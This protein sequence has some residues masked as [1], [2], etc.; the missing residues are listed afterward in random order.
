MNPLHPQR[1][2]L[3][4]RPTRLP[5]TSW[6]ANRR[7]RRSPHPR[8]R[9][10]SPRVRG[11]HRRACFRPPRRLGSAPLSTP[12]KCGIEHLGG[13]GCRNTCGRRCRGCRCFGCWAFWGRPFGTSAAGSSCGGSRAAR[14]NRFRQRCGGVATPLAQILRVSRPV[15][16]LESGL[17]A[18]AN[19][20]RL[21]LGDG[22]PPAGLHPSW[23]TDDELDA[24]FLFEVGK[25]GLQSPASLPAPADWPDPPH[26]R[27]AREN[28]VT[29]ARSADGT[30][31]GPKPARQI[32]KAA[33]RLSY[34]FRMAYPETV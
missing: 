14:F 5:R 29:S 32:A 16:V 28:R 24:G 1:P 30:R 7:N 2:P 8:P 34:E 6:A 20:S 18:G 9:W 26:G 33:S 19:G 21:A 4:L 13:S 22:F 23:L 11:L 17:A 15:R 31:R 10:T 3:R 27:S 12:D 25:L